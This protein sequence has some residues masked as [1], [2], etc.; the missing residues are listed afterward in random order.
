MYS[1]PN[2]QENPTKIRNITDYSGYPQSYL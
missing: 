1:F 2:P